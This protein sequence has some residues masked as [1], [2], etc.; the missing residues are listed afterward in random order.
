VVPQDFHDFFVVS[1]TVSGALIGLLFVAVS[2]APVRL[3][4]QDA[5]AQAQTTAT[6]AFT[7]LISAMF[8]SL[9][10]LIPESNLGDVTAITGGAGLLT[11]LTLAALLWRRR[12]DERLSLR[13]P[14]LLAAIAIVY[15]LALI[16]AFKLLRTPADRGTVRTMTY[17][18]LGLFGIGI[19][20]SWELLGARS[21]GVIE[22]VLRALERRSSRAGPSD[23]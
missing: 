6:T 11:T 21:M 17:V 20:R 10:A 8:I 9:Y 18:I 5:P 3:V 13:T 4:S 1:A 16:F 14:Y 19:A 2:V 7:A 22:S 12:K 23:T 15:V